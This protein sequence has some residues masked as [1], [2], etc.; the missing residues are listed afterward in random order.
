MRYLAANLSKE[1]YRS[2]VKGTNKFPV[3]TKKKTKRKSLPSSTINN[4]FLRVRDWDLIGSVL[5]RCCT[6]IL[7]LFL[8]IIFLDPLKEFYRYGIKKNFGSPLIFPEAS[9]EKTK[10]LIL[11]NSLSSFSFR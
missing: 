11:S 4:T 9:Q 10:K 2:R 7:F 1:S 6:L 3:Q 8:T 5:R